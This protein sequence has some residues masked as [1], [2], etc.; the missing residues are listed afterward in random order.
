MN[1]KSNII[2]LSVLIVFIGTAV[3]FYN[4][5]SKLKEDSNVVSNEEV[6]SLV[7]K[8]SKLILLPQN[9]IPT[10]ATVN[11]PEKLKDQPFFIKAKSGDKVLLYPI[12]K[13]AFLYNPTEDKI[14]EVAPINLGEPAAEKPIKEN[15][16]Q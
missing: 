8:V 4:K 15:K 5:T 3:Y 1:R 9:E 12:A 2:I 11:D 13:R 6:K 14:M 10:V 7:A 16:K